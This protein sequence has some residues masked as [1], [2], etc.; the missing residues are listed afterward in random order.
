MV[1]TM[2]FLISYFG[3]AYASRTT[4]NELVPNKITEVL[5]VYVICGANPGSFGLLLFLQIKEHFGFLRAH[6]YIHFCWVTFILSLLYYR[7]AYDP[8]G[9]STN[10]FINWIFG[11]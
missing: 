7:F 6:F 4:Y 11:S 9:T 2:V 10:Y 3:P 8:T 5:L 1:A